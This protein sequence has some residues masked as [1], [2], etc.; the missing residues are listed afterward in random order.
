MKVYDNIHGDMTD[1][2]GV[3]NTGLWRNFKVKDQ[4]RRR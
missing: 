1:E 2:G 4:G 3:P